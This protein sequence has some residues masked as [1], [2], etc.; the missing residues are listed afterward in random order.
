MVFTFAQEFFT[1]HWDLNK[2]VLMKP[3]T[4]E[5]DREKLANT[6]LATDITGTWALPYAYTVVTH[7]Q[8]NSASHLLIKPYNI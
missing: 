2:L 4:A 6:G 7:G 8:T 1:Y 5:S 3:Q